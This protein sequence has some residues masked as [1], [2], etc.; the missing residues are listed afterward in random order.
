VT[1]LTDVAARDVGAIGRFDG[2]L[3]RGAQEAEGGDGKVEALMPPLVIEFG[4]SLQHLVY[5]AALLAS[6]P[7]LNQMIGKLTGHRQRLADF[8]LTADQRRS[9]LVSGEVE[10]PSRGDAFK[11]NRC[12]RHGESPSRRETNLFLFSA[13]VNF[14]AQFSDRGGG[15]FEQLA[16]GG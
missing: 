2:E 3:D 13:G 14:V 9:L 10:C 7:K 11:E 1:N 4:E 15:P 5:L 6:R 8:Q 16:L 12:H